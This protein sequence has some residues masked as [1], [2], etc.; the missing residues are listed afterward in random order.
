MPTIE[1]PPLSDVA[2]EACDLYDSKL[3]ALLEPDHP[4]ESVA[5][6]VDTGDYALGCTHWQA[7]HVL[8]GRHPPDGRIATLTIVP[9]TDTDLRLAAR[10]IAGPKR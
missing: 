6:H 3:K 10:M 9:P 8:L 1:T 7:A 5:I 4:G 2:Q